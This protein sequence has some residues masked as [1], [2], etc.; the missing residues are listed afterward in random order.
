MRTALAADNPEIMTPTYDRL[1]KSI[2][3]AAVLLA[4]SGQRP[5]T[6][7]PVV[8]A[9]EDLLQ[10]I[11][12]GE[13]WREYT[14]NVINNVGLSA[15]ERMYQKITTYVINHPGVP[16][17]KVMQNFHL[18]SRSADHVLAT[19]EQRGLIRRARA[20]GSRGERLHPY[21]LENS[22]KRKVRMP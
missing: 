19:L 3:K 11:N 8:V 14:N 9:I 20:A 4:A 13:G 7:D 1:C 5:I 17:S 21:S 6:G 15:D 16:R 10:A 18:N 2:L 22:P 12:Y